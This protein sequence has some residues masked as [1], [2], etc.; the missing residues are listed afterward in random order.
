VTLGP[1]DCR[2]PWNRL[3]VHVD[4]AIK[5]CCYSLFNMG[6]IATKV[7]LDAVWTGKEMTHL[8]ESIR[9]N[10]VDRLC[11][12]AGC[13]FVRSEMPDYAVA[14]GTRFR[15]IIPDGVTDE[16]T[17]KLAS[18]GNSDAMFRVGYSLYTKG[19]LGRSILWMERAAHSGEAHAQYLLGYQYC[20]WRFKAVTR[21]RGL[22]LL[23]RACGQGYVPAFNALGGQL[24]LKRQYSAAL[25]LF[26]KG[27]ALNDAECFFWLFTYHDEGIAVP[28]N[29]AE[30]NR[31]LKLAAARGSKTAGDLLTG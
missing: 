18:M 22:E 12:G 25:D 7:D 30:A 21:W 19:Y 26:Q 16:N 4:G 13:S 31:L 1:K 17:R 11:A 23:G 6:N 8:R 29:T 14:S 15:A 3:Y 5:P 10:K 28:Q 20:T 9:A 2:W 27:A 24:H